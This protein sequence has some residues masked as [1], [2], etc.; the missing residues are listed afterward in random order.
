MERSTALKDLISDQKLA[1]PPEG[2]EDLYVDLEGG[3]LPVRLHLSEEVGPHLFFF[4]AEGD[5][6]DRYDQ[7]G[8]DL[9]E[10]GLSLLVIGYRG[11]AQAQGEVDWSNIFDDAL[12]AFDFLRDFLAK[13]GRQGI[14]GLLG[15]SLGAGVALKVAVERVSQ[16]SALILDSPVV[17][18]QDWLAH[19]GLVSDRDP[20]QIVEL[21]K[22]WRK[23]IL[24]FQAQR[25][26]EVSLPQVEK[27]LI[28]CPAR[29]KKLLIMPG[30]KREETIERGGA[31]YAE[32]IAELLNR[33]A[34]R[35]QRKRFH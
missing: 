35:F 16:V 31:L 28:F 17:D 26:E 27:L 19:R 8:Q 30:Y 4:V 21:L 18:G 24:V 25:D 5:T 7:L 23:P 22:A 1:P 6:I 34:G 29:N 11:Q 15:R 9:R 13:R 33:L 3:R 2:S 10:H 12:K 14:V 20:F 32:T